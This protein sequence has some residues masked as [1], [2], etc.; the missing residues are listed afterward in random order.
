MKSSSPIAQ[1]NLLEWNSLI[2][3]GDLVTI[4]NMIEKGDLSYKDQL[5]ECGLSPL[6]LAAWHNQP[7]VCR[8]LISHKISPCVEE[9]FSLKT[10]LH[11]AAYFGHSEVASVLLELEAKVTGRKARDFIGGHHLHYAALGEQEEMIFLF[12]GMTHLIGPTGSKPDP[13]QK[14]KL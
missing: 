8:F 11:I 5:G 13:N 6:H 2:T 9:R 7:E 1:G 4:Q 14:A 12:L 3:K 10:P